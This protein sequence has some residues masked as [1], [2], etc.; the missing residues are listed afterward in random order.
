MNA[1][2]QAGLPAL[3]LKDPKLFREQCYIDGQWVGAD[4]GKSVEVDNPANGKRLGS[5][6]R[7][8]GVAREDRQGARR[9]PAQVVRP[10]DGA[11]G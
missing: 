11:P 3:P 4:S 9:D 1:P 6:P 5:V 8:A 2:S 10:D 7:L